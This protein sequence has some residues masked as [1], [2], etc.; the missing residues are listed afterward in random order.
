MA[1]F[2]E[3]CGAPLKEGDKFCAGCG[4]HVAA[5]QQPNP[6]PQQRPESQQRP[7]PQPSRQPKAQPSK[8]KK[9]GGRVKALLIVALIAV[10]GYGGWE[11]YQDSEAKRTR[12]SLT[13]DYPEKMKEVE[14]RQ[15]T[16]PKTLET[17]KGSLSAEDPT[18]TLC[19]VTV[20]VAPEMLANQCQP[21]TV[22][23]METGVD[24]DGVRSEKYEI[25]MGE[26]KQFEEPVKVTFPCKV[27]PDTDVV[28]RHYDAEEEEWMPLLSFVD[29]ESGTVS[30]YFSSFSPVEVSYLPVGIDPKIYVVRQPYSNE[31]YVLKFGVTSNYL[32]ILKR[33]NPSLYSDEINKFTADPQ[34][35][36]VKTPTLDKSMNTKTAYE[37]FKEASEMWT[38]CDPLINL[39]MESLPP[40]SQQRAVQYLIDNSGKVSSFMNAVPFVVM[41]TQLCFDMHEASQN[42]SDE[43]AL[44]TPAVNLYKN[45]ANSSGT[46]YSLATNYSHIG[47][48]LA[49]FGVALIGMEIDYF[50]DQAKAA[51]VENVENVFNAYYTKTQPIDG[52]HWYTMFKNAYWK[53][54]GNIKAAMQDM[55]DA[56]D[57][58]CEKFWRDVY[59]SNSDDFWFAIGD[60]KYRKV[61]EDATWQQ[62][63]ALTEQQK[64]KVWQLIKY[65]SM[66]EI[67][68]FL[69]VR[70]QEKIY[71]QLCNNPLVK[72]YNKELTIKIHEDLGAES[73]QAQ[74]AGRT[75]CLGN[76]G[77]PFKDWYYNVPD[78]AI[79][80]GWDTEFIPCTMYGYIKMGMPNQ[81]LVFRSEKDFERDKEPIEI[82]AFELNKK[83]DVTEIEL[84][85]GKNLL[86]SDNYKGDHIERNPNLFPNTAWFESLDDAIGKTQ[87]NIQ[88]DGSFEATAIGERE[89]PVDNVIMFGV[90]ELRATNESNVTF[91]GHINKTNGNGKFT[92]RS[93][94]KPTSYTY[95]MKN[96][97]VEYGDAPEQSGTVIEVTGDVA[98]VINDDETSFLLFTGPGTMTLVDGKK[99]DVGNVSF[100]F[101]PV[102]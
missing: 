51:K 69:M 45:L 100:Y 89:G 11:Y 35:Y 12:E 46:I 74:Y 54:D 20:E 80:I 83:G 50:I 96:G 9:N 34:N 37:A 87:I 78:D 3:Y 82:I 57:N 32:N 71:K 52:H 26:H 60:S 42:L 72:E 43:D 4:H 10:L 63:Q 101:K 19:G 56:V 39:G 23:R 21:I 73:G 8:P 59:D 94:T 27:T 68:D 53:H 36:S 62:K 33:I 97:D 49:F 18:I 95:Y 92:M 67:E 66:G 77:K 24:V 7:Q 99:L 22:S 16:M 76:D 90:A 29:T 91:N 30:A 47:F 65:E 93:F 86:M 58:Y 64:S 13:K 61:F 28:V 55:K 38:F 44:K 15:H 98:L 48:S 41:G 79:D 17:K 88:K 81:V 2:C 25:E 70:M 84:N 1:K 14:R 102:E 85:K 31:P 5:P 6:Q 40:S 75:I